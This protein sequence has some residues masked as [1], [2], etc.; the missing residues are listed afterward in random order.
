MEV[1]NPQRDSRVEYCCKYINSLGRKN[2]NPFQLVIPKLREVGTHVSDMLIG[3]DIQMYDAL[4]IASMG[5]AFFVPEYP[6]IV[7]TSCLPSL[8]LRR[9][10]I[11]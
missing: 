4:E 1:V 11:Y 8:P 5:D 7:F 6:G 10:Q 3:I 2:F 9:G